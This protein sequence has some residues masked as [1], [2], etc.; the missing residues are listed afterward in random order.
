MQ[1][2]S[3]TTENTLELKSINEILNGQF[4]IPHYQRGYRWTKQQV[5][6][7]LN[8]IDSFIPMQIPG[9]QGEE[10]FYCLQ[11]IVLKA[12]NDKTIDENNLEGKWYEVIDGQQRLTTIYLIIHYANEMWTGKQKKS[13]IAINYETRD[14]CVKVLN[15]LRVE[16]DNNVLINS[17]YI[18]Y[19]YISNAYNTINQWVLNYTLNKNKPFDTN[20]FQSKFNSNSKIIWYEVSENEN[21]RKLFER[22]NLGKIPLTNAELIKA[23]FLSSSSFRDLNP[24]EKQIKR[25]EIARLWDE[26]EQK[27][28]ESDAKFWSFITNKKRNTFATKIELILD[29]IANKAEN[30]KD[31]LATFLF[32]NRKQKEEGLSK[33]W[34]LIEHYYLTLNEWY[35]D[36][37]LYHKVGYLIT[38]KSKV[39]IKELVSESVISTKSSFDKYL[40]E[41]ISE[42]VNFEIS[43][44]RYEDHYWKIQNLLLLFNVETN[45]VSDA[46]SEFYPFKL[47]K[48]NYWSIEHIHAR[49]SENFD[50]SKKDPWLD[51]LGIHKEIITEL[52]NNDHFNRKQLQNVLEDIDHYNNKLITWER[53]SQLFNTINNIF[54]EDKDSLD[55][56][57]EGI[58]N[59]ALLSQPDNAV[60]NNSVFEVKRR[61]IIRLD[62]EGS[63][64]PI[65]TR[66]VFLK[67]YKEETINHQYHFWTKSDRIE[68]GRAIRDKLKIYLPTTN[69][70]QDEDK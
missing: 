4:F 54:T 45:R 34:Q 26:M 58:L 49:N 46:I 59:L 16:N 3:Q 52:L 70:V 39:S 17:D 15:D 6:D 24:E 32:F 63:F 67:Y 33:I 42:T 66:R 13:E 7:L 62:K 1:I 56:E 61:E 29:M 20:K 47:H 55:M 21:G 12:C 38:S 30:E 43:E 50:K 64:I 8:D 27:L 2:N 35:K 41:K 57:S 19:Y 44:L 69:T 31:P 53:F 68:Y 25:I 5:E 18:D 10:T 51:W 65:C 40:K 22:L 11:P 48:G 14:N 23:L 9:T 36:K 60:L 37:D 28:N